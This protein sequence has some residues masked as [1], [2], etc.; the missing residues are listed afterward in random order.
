MGKDN[1]KIL[2]FQEASEI[3]DYCHMH[4]NDDYEYMVGKYVHLIRNNIDLLE[5]LKATCCIRYPWGAY[6]YRV[7]GEWYDLEE[8]GNKVGFIENTIEVEGTIEDREVKIGSKTLNIKSNINPNHYK[9]GGLET[10][11]ILEAKLTK[12]EL[13][14]FCKGNIIKYITR[15]EL[16]NGKEDLQ[17]AEWYLDKLINVFDN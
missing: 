17:K 12:E 14:G 4:D 15:S 7:G 5:G 1:D 13:K 16:K 9:S 2:T 10:F 3:G 11:E 8:G 6:K